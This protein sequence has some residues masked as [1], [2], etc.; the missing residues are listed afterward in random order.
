MR[1]LRIGGGLSHVKEASITTH[2]P[3]VEVF[4]KPHNLSLC[5]PLSICFCQAALS[6]IN[7]YVS[8]L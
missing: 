7:L 2:T 3:L 1:T 4:V 6:I 5:L 8:K